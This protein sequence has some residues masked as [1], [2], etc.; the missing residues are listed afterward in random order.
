MLEYLN[1]FAGACATKGMEGTR[2]FVYITLLMMEGCDDE[3]WTDY[4]R[5]AW[6]GLAATA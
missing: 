3:P 2:S 4:M 5:G 6:D 1:A